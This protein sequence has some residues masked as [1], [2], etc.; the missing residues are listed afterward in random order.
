M[1]EM[2]ARLVAGK[3]ISELGHEPT[4]GQIEAIDL[5]SS[6]IARADQPKHLHAF[7]LKGYAGTGKTTLVSALVRV[8][9]L[10]GM[11][12]VLLAPTGRAAK[13]LGGY[14]RKQAF[15]IHRKIYRASQNSDGKLQ[16]TLA[17]NPHKF[18]LFIV[19][20]A[21]MIPG[22]TASADQGIYSHRDILE[23]L[24]TYIYKSEGCRLLLIGDGAQLPPVGDELSPALNAEYLRNLY[25][26]DI[27]SYELSEVVR[28]SLDSGVLA[29]AT[30]LRQFANVEKPTP[31]F[32][33][34]N[35]FADIKKIDG[36]EF[37]DSLNSCYSRFGVENT[38]IITRSNKRANLF[39]NEVR[40]RMLFRET[41]L[42]A[43]DIIMITKN[44]YFWLPKGSKAGFIANGDMA[45]VRRIRNISEMYGFRFAEITIQLLD[46][47]DEGVI[48]IKLLLD[49]MNA[50]SASMPQEEIKKLYDEILLDYTEISPASAR[51][52]KVKT[53]PFYNAVQAKFAYSLTCHKTQG[54]QWDA[55]FIDHGYLTDEMIDSS[56]M[57]W[58]YTAVTRT[59][60]EL[61]LVNF[62]ESFFEET[63]SK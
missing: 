29:N 58:L 17:A 10:A 47:P 26:L 30:M 3:I 36:A 35:G 20:E 45:E 11:Q 55:V 57:K 27:D 43:G 19:D 32:F 2:D 8:L 52:E 22:P 18:T 60:K 15:T 24:I 44:N 13:V 51:V 1:L 63:Q 14:S 4:G 31:P 50:V 28:Q 33:N 25:H 39:N 49:S 59:A 53:S 16:M 7:M 54:G 6:F 61:Y 40:A 46:Y 41:E 37:E 12:S 42:S 23:D 56:F 9:P 34:L 48:E 21:S 62:K 5:I 38:A